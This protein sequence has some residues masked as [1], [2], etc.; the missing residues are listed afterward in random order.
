MQCA[1]GSLSRS[2]PCRPPLTRARR[3]SFL[4]RPLEFIG[5]F[6]SALKSYVQAKDVASADKAEYTIGVEGSFGANR[7]TPRNL[8]ARHLSSLVCVEGIITKCECRAAP[9]APRRAACSLGRPP[10]GA[11][12]LLLRS[13]PLFHSSLSL[14]TV[15]AVRC[16]GVYWVLLAARS[17]SALSRC[18]TPCVPFSG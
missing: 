10:D 11:F 18:P 16:G 6:Q 2:A 13:R 12:P 4:R 9:T 15:A 5:P 1:S 8:M 17:V 7:V 14:S 3:C